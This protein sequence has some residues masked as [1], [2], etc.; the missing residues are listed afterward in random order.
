[1]TDE[2]DFEATVKISKRSKNRSKSS[3]IPSTQPIRTHILHPIP[4]K[5]EEPSPTS[6]LKTSSVNSS[7]LL[8]T[9]SA[10]KPF[11]PLNTIKNQQETKNKDNLTFNNLI[12]KRH[13][14]DLLEK[15]NQTKLRNIRRTKSES[16]I[17]RVEK[18]MNDHENKRNSHSMTNINISTNN[19]EAVKENQK[20]NNILFINKNIPKGENFLQRIHSSTTTSSSPT[21]T[22]STI[23]MNI[24]SGISKPNLSM[25]RFPCSLSLYDFTILIFR[26]KD[27]C[28]NLVKFLIPVGIERMN[29][30]F[31]EAKFESFL[32]VYKVKFP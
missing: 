30:K 7:V 20:K 14:E 21:G 16:N 5:T 18:I 24:N 12:V 4:I 1:L 32:C 6:S 25:L 19:T 31:F 10:F 28:T 11:K 23:G 3:F 8:P 29:S 26:L 13:L 22:N 15:N 17:N 2:V 27:T 9:N